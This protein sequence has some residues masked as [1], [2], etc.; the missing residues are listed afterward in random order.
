MGF[1]NRIIDEKST[2]KPL[3][4]FMG[5]GING[6]VPLS[7]LLRREEPTEVR[8]EREERSNGP[9][10]LTRPNSSGLCQRSLEI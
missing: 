3:S 2:S 7:T 1:T 9:S 10:L 6:E 8:E 4:D 5:R